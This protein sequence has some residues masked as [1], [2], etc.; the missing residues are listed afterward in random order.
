MKLLHVL[1][2][3]G[4]EFVDGG[5]QPCSLGADDSGLKVTG[6]VSLLV[7]DLHDLG[8]GHSLAR[9]DPRSMDRSREVSRSRSAMP[10]RSMASRALGRIRWACSLPS[11][12]GIPQSLALFTGRFACCRQCVNVIGYD[13]VGTRNPAR[14][15]NLAEIQRRGMQGP[16]QPRAVGIRALDGDP[17]AARP[18][19]PVDSGNGLFEAWQTCGECGRIRDQVGGRIQ[20]DVCVGSRVGVHADDVYVVLADRSHCR[21]FLL[22]PGH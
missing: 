1:N 17:G 6:S 9:I 8:I 13:A 14:R 10:W 19:A 12:R 21:G 20:D 15:A 4:P 22:K 18:T 11:E 7:A 5:G 2:H 16:G 3:S